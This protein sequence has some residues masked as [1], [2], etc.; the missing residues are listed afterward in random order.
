M[1]RWAMGV[2][3]DGTH[4]CGWQQQSGLRTLEAAFATAISQVADHTI[5]L[6]CGGRTDSGVHAAGQVLHFDSDAGRSARAWV[7]GTNANLDR[8]ASVSWASPVPDFFHARFSALRRHYRYSILNRSARSALHEGRSLWVQAPL[9]AQLMH[10]GGQYLLGE[11]DFSAFRAA[12]C[13]SKSP[14]R[15]LDLLA[16]HREHDL[17]HIDVAANAFLHHMVRNIAGLLIE[18][19]RGL[20]PP[21]AVRALLEGRDRRRNAP[22]ADPEGLCLRRIEYPAA[23]HLPDPV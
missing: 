13:Q 8:K 22:T 19:G 6:T 17:V 2:E 21:E 18:V 23:F 5:S 3:Y 15:R 1:T 12:E 20:R 4:F 7:L 14:V 9:D 10:D 11:H 16:V